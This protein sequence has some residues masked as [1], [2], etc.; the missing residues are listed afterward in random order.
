MASE[1]CRLTSFFFMYY[2]QSLVGAFSSQGTAGTQLYPTSNE[3]FRFRLTV[4]EAHLLDVF[5]HGGFDKPGQGFLGSNSLPD[6]GGGYRLV[7]VVEQVQGHTGQNHV[8]LNGLLRKWLGHGR[9]WTEFFRQGIGH[10]RQGIPRSACHNKVTFSQQ[11]FCIMPFRDVGKCIHSY[12]EEQAVAFLKRLFDLAY[13]ID[14]VIRLGTF[15]LRAG[16]DKFL[17]GF[18]QGRDK[19][20]VVLGS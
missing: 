2:A 4:I 9:R 15:P 7:D 8:T 18:E 1:T 17:R 10:I 12:Q 6:Y 14:A 5:R 3:V 16:S 13:G 19:L 11:G 20:L